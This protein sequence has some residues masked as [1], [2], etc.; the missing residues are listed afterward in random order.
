MACFLG[1]KLV[2]DDDAGCILNRANEV[3]EH[4]ISRTSSRRR[5]NRGIREDV[6][7]WDESPVSFRFFQHIDELLIE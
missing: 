2:D 1:V 5:G 4:L 7:P 3:S 6:L